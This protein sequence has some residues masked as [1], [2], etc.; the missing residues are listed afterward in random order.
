MREKRCVSLAKQ[1]AGFAAMTFVPRLDE[2]VRIGLI[3]GTG[4]GDTVTLEGERCIALKR[5]P[6][7]EAL[8]ELEGHRREL[9][10]GTLA[11][12]TVLVQRG[13]IHCYEGN[14]ELVGLQ[15]DLMHALGVRTLIGCAAV[16]SMLDEPMPEP[17][18]VV[19]FD[20]F[21]PLFGGPVP[22]YVGEFFCSDA[23]LD[24]ELIGIALAAERNGLEVVT[25]G[26]AMIRGPDFA[27]PKYGY[28][29]LRQ[30]GAD[31]V[32]M[33][34]RPEA[35]EVACYSD[36]PDKRT[37]MLA[38]GNVTDTARDHLTHQL[39]LERACKQAPLLG[40]FLT[41]IVRRLPE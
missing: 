19:A 32:G 14:L 30:S 23:A 25:G 15:V 20:G 2:R 35:H 40:A 31:Y 6:G 3:L 21:C 28:R 12:K 27:G 39:V 22:G 41:D 37:R 7:F 17:G 36:H 1:A 9:C 33:S 4:W 24:P 10:V 29:L 11:G 8:G 26:H 38:L 34:L 18:R 16:G 5:I 13:R